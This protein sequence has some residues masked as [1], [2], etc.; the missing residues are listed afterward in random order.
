MVGTVRKITEGKGQGGAYGYYTRDSGTKTTEMMGR[1]ILSEPEW[2]EAIIKEHPEMKGPIEEVIMHKI[3]SAKTPDEAADIMN[4]IGVTRL[5][6]ILS[7]ETYNELLS[8]MGKF[9]QLSTDELKR[10]R[11]IAKLTKK[12]VGVGAGL[13]AGKLLG[14]FGG[15]SK[16]KGM[17]GPM[18]GDFE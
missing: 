13:E 9:L 1:K 8:K 2:P 11:T 4:R 15:E 18:G 17:M 3:A 7:E 16:N 6:R 10:Y 5:G 12:T 14:F